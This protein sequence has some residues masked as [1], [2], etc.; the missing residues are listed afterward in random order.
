MRQIIDVHNNIIKV[1]PETETDFI[2]EL[3][4]FI[5][6]NIWNKAPEITSSSE[7]Y[8]PYF[9][10]LFKYIPNYFELNEGDEQWMIECR[11]I[12]AGNK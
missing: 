5:D 8:I 2:K 6:A 9:N 3:Q 1:I 10:I 12:F 4:Q 7:V 11:D